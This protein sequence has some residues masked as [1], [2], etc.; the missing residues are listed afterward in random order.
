MNYASQGFRIWILAVLLVLPSLCHAA[1]CEK[2]LHGWTTSSGQHEGGVVVR[3][4]FWVNNPADPG[5][6]TYEGITIRDH[7]RWRGWALIN[8]AKKG[9]GDQPKFG[10]PAYRA[11]VK[12]L[13]QKLIAN[14]E[15]Q[16]LVDDQYHGDQWEQIRGDEIISQYLAYKL[17]RLGINMGT[18]TAIIILEKTINDLNGKDEDFPLHGVLTAGHVTWLNE[19]TAPEKLVD[20]TTSNWRRWCFFAQLK[21]NALD[22]YGDLIAARPKLGTFWETWSEDAEHDR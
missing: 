17:V 13:N 9:L 10:T 16:K 5:G 7:K 18:G 2:A 12:R 22:R 15:L 1:D 6:E 4:G 21:L 8:E 14:A 11:W 3:E 19:F 20:G